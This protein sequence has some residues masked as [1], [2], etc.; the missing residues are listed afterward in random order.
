MNIFSYSL[1]KALKKLCFSDLHLILKIK[2]GIRHLTNKGKNIKLI[3]LP[4]HADIVRNERADIIVKNTIRIGVDT[5]ISVPLGEIKNYWKKGSI[6][7]LKTGTLQA[8]LRILDITKSFSRRM[9]NPGLIRWK[10]DGY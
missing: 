6:Q 2:D 9:E 8:R 10:R 7:N 1:L 5:Q 3:R 4:S